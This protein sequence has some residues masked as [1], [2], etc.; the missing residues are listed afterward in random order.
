MRGPE[1]EESG[2]ELSMK[3]MRHVGGPSKFGV[4]CAGD[5][6]VVEKGDRGESGVEEEEEEDGR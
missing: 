4:G 2:S 6:G 1:L 5:V 3:Q